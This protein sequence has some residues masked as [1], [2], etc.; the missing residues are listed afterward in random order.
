MP[1]KYERALSR[2]VAL[3]TL[4]K[5]T[6]VCNS[7]IKP[8]DANGVM[9]Y[10]TISFNKK[11]GKIQETFLSLV[12]DT[13]K[14]EC[15]MFLQPDE[16]IVI[17]L[18]L[19]TINAFENMNAESFETTMELLIHE[20]SHADTRTRLHKLNKG[21][22]PVSSIARRM[23]NMIHDKW[24]LLH[25]LSR[26]HQRNPLLVKYPMLDHVAHFPDEANCIRISS[27]SS[28]NTNTYCASV[29][30]LHVYSPLT[31]TT[32]FLHN[33]E[34]A[35]NLPCSSMLMQNLDPHFTAANL[36]VQHDS[37]HSDDTTIYSTFFAVSVGVSTCFF[38]AMASQI[39]NCNLFDAIARGCRRLMP[40]NIT[41]I[42]NLKRD[43][44]SDISG[45]QEHEYTALHAEYDVAMDTTSIREHAE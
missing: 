43:R 24:D 29:E 42:D 10:F 9:R 32:Q 40:M 41:R 1:C 13:H 30:L 2:A 20:L 16:D 39:M 8:A 12:E 33:I 45:K 38:V 36:Y 7:T 22:P 5:P 26:H 15:I 3:H 27:Y 35:I 19:R 6:R 17:P 21:M 34:D 18:A 31:Y 4:S 11:K 44:I 28:C 14:L 23:E 37:G 25:E